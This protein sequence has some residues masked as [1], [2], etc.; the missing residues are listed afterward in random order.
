MA[1]RKLTEEEWK[2]IWACFPDQH[3]GRPRRWSD[4]ECLDAVLYVLH[5]GC[6]WKELPS[7]F[8]PKSTAYDRFT[9]WS[10]TGVL[11]KVFKRLRR[12][13]PLGK[14][15]Y[16]DSTVKSAK[17]GQVR[18]ASSESKRQQAKSH[19]WRDWIT[20]RNPL[21]FCNTAWPVCMR[22]DDSKTSRQ[23]NYCSG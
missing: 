21:R 13:L 11:M 1:Y 22:A 14:V 6:R 15:F 17:K 23:L 10:K 12:R 3:M 7:G 8:P 16:I 18:R 4:R 19:L 20:C 9:L 2:L 5:T